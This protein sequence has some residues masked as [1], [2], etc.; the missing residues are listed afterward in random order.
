MRSVH[1]A[2]IEV[3]AP[4]RVDEGGKHALEIF[5]HHRAGRPVI[6]A[7]GNCRRRDGLPSAFVLRQEFAAAPGHIG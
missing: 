2:G 3:G 1:L 5:A 6:L 7:E 4:R